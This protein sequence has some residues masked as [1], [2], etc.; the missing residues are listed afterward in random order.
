MLEAFWSLLRLKRTKWQEDRAE[1]GTW[2]IFVC[3]HGE[4][5]KIR[6]FGTETQMF[7]QGNIVQT[8][9]NCKELLPK[10]GGLERF[11]GEEKE[12]KGQI[13]IKF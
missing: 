9:A 8:F 2:R 4:R 6:R 5:G 13:A 3:G 11:K 1:G 12:R 7:A 10:T